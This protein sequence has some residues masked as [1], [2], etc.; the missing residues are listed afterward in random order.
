LLQSLPARIEEVAETADVEV[1]VVDNDPEG[2]ARRTVAEMVTPTKYVVEPTP[3][4]AAARNRALDECRNRDL[5]AFIDDDEVPRPAWLAALLAVWVEYRSSA[6]WG[7]VISVFDG[8]VDPWVVATGTFRR[9]ERPT[10]LSLSVAAAGNLLLHVD[11]L[12]QL[13]MRF[14]ESIGLAGGE[15]TLFTRQLVER[16]G[17]IVW[18]NESETVD[19]VAPR[20]VS[21][22]WA[23]HRAYSAANTTTHVD[24]RLATSA[25]GRAVIR[26][27]A[28][29]GGIA[30]VVVGLGRH[31]YGRVSSQL[32]HDAR[33]LRLTYRGRG[34]L[35]A[36]CG[37]HYQEYQR[38]KD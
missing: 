37:H 23:M 33:G 20:R 6:V 31:L 36:A 12:D 1:L 10:G 15:D 17:T 13:D 30:R 25:V 5:V 21:R 28:A 29:A 32:E 4:I 24:L 19:V 18:C 2:S 16:G 22:E 11:A 35:A 26:F 3:G 9:P 14:D 27:R 34:M 8:D 38:Q 7:R